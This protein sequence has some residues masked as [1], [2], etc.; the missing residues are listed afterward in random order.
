MMGQI[1]FT[2]DS[3]LTLAIGHN[4]KLQMAEEQTEAAKYERKAAKTN[5]LP[6]LSATGTYMYNQK[7]VSL[8][9]E[10]Q[11]YDLNH[12]GDRLTS[13]LEKSFG[14]L[15]DDHT[16][17]TQLIAPLAAI[18][19]A[20]PLNELGH[21]LTEALQ[22][23]THHIWAG[24]VSLTQ[25]LYMGGKIRAYYQITKQAETLAGSQR[26]TERQKVI[27][28]TETAYWTVISLSARQELAKEYVHLVQTL[29]EDM[30]K[31]YNAGVVTR[32]DE[33]MVKVKAGEADMA[34]T[35]VTNGLNLSRMLLCQ[36]CG[37]PLDTTLRL[38]DEEKDSIA[39]QPLPNKE[40]STEFALTHRPELRSLEA[41]VE[42]TRLNERIVRAEYLPSVALT[43]NYLVS[44][45]SVLNGFERKF[46]GTWNVGILLNIPLFQ[47]GEGVFKTRESRAETRSA[48][49]RLIEAREEIALQVQQC[50]YRLEEAYKRLTLTE[51]NRR[52]AEENL[53]Y[54]RLGFHEGV[55]STTQ[56]LEAQTAWLSARVA[57]VDAQIGIK[58][59]EA[60]MR[61]AMGSP[62]QLPQE[63]ERTAH[64]KY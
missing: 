43:G 29:E 8:L 53:R 63:G 52:E 11:R 5:F 50:K 1:L 23:N 28:E 17:L 59:A 42:M 9:S 57:H 58:L 40:K 10:Q 26:E 12:M 31:M 45:P 44:N 62:L 47:W 41:V 2:R 19:I 33:L 21:A 64:N 61:R 24:G 56:L 51:S 37:L 55:T 13:A 38:A 36:L 30:E 15:G 35:Q 16:M 32:A 14:Q 39:I 54:A 7:T 4:R 3:L 18:D 60:E 25:P 20:T 22:T 27:E 48:E 46:K 6:K 49:W 34:L